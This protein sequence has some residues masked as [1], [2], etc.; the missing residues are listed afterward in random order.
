VDVDEYRRL[1]EKTESHWWFGATSKLIELLLLPG[2]DRLGSTAICLDAGGGTG[3]TSSWLAQR[4]ATALCEYEPMAIEAAL[5]R[6]PSFLA[7]RGDINMLPYRDGSF[8]IAMCVTA[9][10]HEMNP[11]PAATVRELARVV[12]PGGRLLLLEPHHPWLYRGHDRVTHTA[13]RFRLA[14]LRGH[15]EHADLTIE[16]ATAAFSFLV[17]PAV[18]VKLIDRKGSKSDVGRNESG[19]GGLAGQL[20]ALERR[21]LARH[22]LRFGLSAVVVGRKNGEA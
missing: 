18:A 9:L 17:P 11:D 20:S 2:G 4:V 21:W 5:D 16:R 14:T 19:L 7:T 12:A 15:V 1:I 6:Y 22:D 13:R 10:C 3:A 8:D